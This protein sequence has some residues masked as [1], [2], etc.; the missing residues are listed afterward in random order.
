MKIETYVIGI[1]SVNC[2]LVSNEETKEC[3][4]VDPGAYD[5]AIADHIKEEGLKMQAILLTHGHFDHIMGIDGF[6]EKFPVPVYACGEE[7]ALLN[8]TTLNVSKRICEGY[9]F[10]GATYLKDGEKLNL[11]GK[12]ITVLH[13]PGHTSGGCCYY[14]PSEGV[15]FSGDTLF[16]RSVGRSDFPTGD[17][18]TLARSIREKLLCLPDETKVFPGHMGVTTIGEERE[19][20]P[21]C[22]K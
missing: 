16:R 6:L 10:S 3:F 22:K 14:I 21:F 13:T 1:V 19:Y 11:I 12:E 17:G 4:L 9:T 2:Y 18:D 5:A 7:E 8:D 15:L 20:N